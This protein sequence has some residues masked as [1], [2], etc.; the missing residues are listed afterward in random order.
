MGGIGKGGKLERAA[1]SRQ[2]R[3]IDDDD[4]IPP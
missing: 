4:R 2:R 1:F 3:L